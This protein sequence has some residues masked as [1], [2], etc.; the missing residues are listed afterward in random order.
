MSKEAKLF[1]SVALA[2][3]VPALVAACVL[4]AGCGKPPAAEPAVGVGE[5]VGKTRAGATITRIEVDTGTLY[6]V[7][8][9][10][11]VAVTHV[12]KAK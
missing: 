6:V 5:V 12:P 4:A 7:E 9:A 10:N 11:R 3:L 2:W 8:C 1:G